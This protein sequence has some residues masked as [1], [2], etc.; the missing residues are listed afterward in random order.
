MAHA[1]E[2]HAVVNLAGKLELQRSRKQPRVGAAVLHRIACSA[3]WRVANCLP[4][5]YNTCS[6][7]NSIYVHVVAV[8]GTC[9]SK[10]NA[11]RLR[12]CSQ[13]AFW[14]DLLLLNIQ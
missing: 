7:M 11:Q 3:L 8:H 2:P 14:H 1:C 12:G 10:C 9:V 13:G 6:A 4:V 5:L